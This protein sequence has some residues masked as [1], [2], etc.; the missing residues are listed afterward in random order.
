MPCPDPMI[1][2]LEP[3]R[4][5]FT[6]PTWKKMLTSSEEPSWH[7]GAELSPPPCGKPAISRMPTLA[8]FTK[9]GSSAHWPPLEASGQL[10]ALIVP[11]SGYFPDLVA[12]ERVRQGAQGCSG[13][14][15]LHGWCN[16]TGYF[17]CCEID[18]L[19]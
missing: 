15:S 13:C 18:P 10:L 7:A 17:P 1:L 3:F 12:N 19:S 8:V 4:P 2:M 9:C 11:C 14:L 16:S 6:A 5:L